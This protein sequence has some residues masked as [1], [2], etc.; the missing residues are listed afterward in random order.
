MAEQQREIWFRHYRFFRF[1]PVHWKG[2]AIILSFI[3]GIPAIEV[4]A[5]QFGIA[6]SSLAWLLVPYF[7][8]GM[9][10]GG[11]IIGHTEGG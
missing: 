3:A 4:A 9:Y 7:A 5:A 11:V 6:G 1:W 10:L 8:F 2:L